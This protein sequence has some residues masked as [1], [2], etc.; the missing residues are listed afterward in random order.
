MFRIM[1]WAIRIVAVLLVIGSLSLTA[2]VLMFSSV[3]FLVS[4]A[5]EA[6]TGAKTVYSK[7]TT[8]VKVQE[9]K[10]TTLSNDLTDKN[11]KL[12]VANNKITKQSD[13]I[14]KLGGKVKNLESS[15]AK[16]FATLKVR[17]N[18]MKVANAKIK[19][20][21]ELSLSGVNPVNY[22]G[23]I[24]PAL[25]VIDDAT[26]RIFRRTATRATRDVGSL[27]AQSIPYIGIAALVGATVWDL[28]DSC[29]T[30]KDIQELKKAFKLKLDDENKVCGLEVPSVTEVWKKA[31]EASKETWDATKEFIPDLPDWEK[32]KKWLNPKEWLDWF[33]GEPDN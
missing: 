15:R 28:K 11:K 8:K 32:T 33:K 26:I 1:K 16:K 14:V 21:T 22:R 31:S 17:K 30:V 18:E 13:E 20:L 25:S 23:K 29:D 24:K 5:I 9:G 19:K 27:A 4:N 3:A 2:G 7:L 10:I 12:K 6:V